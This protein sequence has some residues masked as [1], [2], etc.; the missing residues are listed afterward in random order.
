MADTSAS[1]I[2]L[3]GPTNLD[4]GEEGT[5]GV[6]IVEG[7]T[8]PVQVRPDG[9]IC[10]DEPPPPLPS[11]A[12]LPVPTEVLPEACESTA[13]LVTRH[14]PITEVHVDFTVEGGTHGVDY[15]TVATGPDGRST[16]LLFAPD[17]ALP[18]EG[19]TRTFTIRARGSALL[20]DGQ[21]GPTVDVALPVRQSPLETPAVIAAFTDY[22]LRSQP[23]SG[24]FVMIKPSGDRKV[25][26]AHGA[27]TSEDPDQAC[28]EL[29]ALLSTVNE[30]VHA[31]QGFAGFAAFVTG[32]G[33]FHSTVRDQLA[34]E[35]PN[36]SK[37]LVEHEVFNLKA[38][39]EIRPGWIFG[40]GH[41]TPEDS[42]RSL[43]F[44][45]PPGTVAHFFQDRGWTEHRAH[46]G[47]A[48]MFTVR[49][50][51][52]GYTRI[53][54]LRDMAAVPDPHAVCVVYEPYWR[55]A[56]FDA[57]LSALGFD[58]VTI[59][60]QGK[61]RSDCEATQTT[62]QAIVTRPEASPTPASPSPSPAARPSPTP[63]SSPTA[64]PSPVVT[65]STKP[66]SQPSTPPSQQPDTA[67][68][69]RITSPQDG[70][71]FEA[72]QGNHKEGYWVDVQL[73][74][75]AHDAEDGI[76]TLRW[77]TTAD[78]KASGQA[79]TRTLGTGASIVAR[80]YTDGT[81]DTPHLITVTATDSAG[82]AVVHQIRIVVYYVTG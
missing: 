38:I 45:G 47:A 41:L 14:V 56:Q 39:G 80:L 6:E 27:V 2:R 29:A 81:R 19:E 18:G 11:V 79:T 62:P 46:N 42:I 16:T 23:N 49:L 7:A 53:D 54:S 13:E 25:Q 21:A 55:D 33:T 58:P 57:Q 10:R 9:T 17:W 8:W 76:P 73:V 67:P 82:N 43:L 22:E 15:L 26:T 3:T 77:T 12:P 74:A 65:P 31:L 20:E 52:S 70:S 75:D 48:G 51:A 36:N 32:L 72:V 61:R 50:G 78:E 24:A 66:T 44:L 28:Q 5:F 40:I 35:S 68:T 4:P 34:P 69:V 63:S 37:C 64:T 30:P 60:E 59:R 1:F 71:E